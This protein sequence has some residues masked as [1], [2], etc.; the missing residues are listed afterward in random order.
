MIE[1]LT[2]LSGVAYMKLGAIF[3]F[4]SS[5]HTCTYASSG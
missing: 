5:T 4:F 1:D 3:S 2:A